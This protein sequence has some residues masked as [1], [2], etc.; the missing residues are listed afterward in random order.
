VAKWYA[1]VLGASAAQLMAAFHLPPA[2]S[3]RPAD[4]P[5]AL[6]LERTANWGQY[7]CAVERVRS[8]FAF[9]KPH[10]GS[11]S[12]GLESTRTVGK[13]NAQFLDK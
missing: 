1:V 10:V 8:S 9:I 2:A 7:W 5:Q 13:A 3:A 4:H 11:G 6:V 12:A